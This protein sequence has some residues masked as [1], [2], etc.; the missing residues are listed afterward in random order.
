[1]KNSSVKEYLDIFWTMFKIGICTFGGGYAMIAILERELAV[2][3]KWVSQEE[4][5]D[6]IAV[7]QIT[8]GIIAVNMSTFVGRK[9]KGIPGAIFATLGVVTPSIIIIM[10]IAAFLINFQ[11]NEY[12]QHALAGI[13]ICVCALIINATVGFIKKTVIDLLT[14][15]VFVCIFL[16]A[17][18]TRIDTVIFVLGMLAVSVVLTLVFGEKFYIAKKR[19]DEK[20]QKSVPDIEKS[21]EE[22]K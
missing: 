7:G 12:V 15:A 18:F 10:I 6:Y 21:Q 11:E 8:P 13:R 2:R 22:E 5:I 17:A 9:K 1:M 4:I 14:L 19:G 20:D 3:R 16:L